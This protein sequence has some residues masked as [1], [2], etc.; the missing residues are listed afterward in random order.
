MNNI[1][2]I[3][4]IDN[5]LDE[6]YFFAIKSFI[7]SQHF[8]WFYMNFLTFDEESEYSDP[9]AYLFYHK[10]CDAQHSVQSEHFHLLDPIFIKLNAKKIIRVKCN[11]TP[12]KEIILQNRFHTDFSRG[13]Y[14]GAKT[15]VYY[16]NTNNGYTLFR[17]GTKVESVEN[18]MVIFDQQMA[19]TGTSC[20]DKSNRIVL[21]INYFDE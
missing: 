20:T 6:E 9:E 10:F 7:T 12:K 19:H 8:P 11:L 3:Q 14:P 17:D 18:R 4:I 13:A 16:I 21:N 2:Q 1:N 15:A 5:F